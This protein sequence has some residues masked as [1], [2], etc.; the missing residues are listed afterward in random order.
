M[1]RKL[2][3]VGWVE[4]SKPN[5]IRQLLNQ[6]TSVVLPDDKVYFVESRLAPIASS[7]KLNSVS[8]L[9]AKMLIYSE[10]NLH[11]RVVE[12]LMTTETFFFG[13]IILLKLCKN[14]SYQN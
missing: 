4:E 5:I 11:E 12:T 1:I 13:I 7:E 10:N 8:Q 9:I 6:K 14:S 3:V 2:E